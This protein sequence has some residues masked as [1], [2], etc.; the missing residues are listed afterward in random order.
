QQDHRDLFRFLA[1]ELGKVVQ[2]DA[3]AQYDDSANKVNWHLCDSCP[4]FN[5]QPLTDI[6]KEET[7]A[8]WVHQNQKPL[9]IPFVDRETRFGMTM[10]LLK[11]RGLQSVCALPMA[12]A[13]RRLGSLVLASRVEDAYSEEEVRFLSLVANQIALAMD[14]SLNFQESQR[15]QERL[16]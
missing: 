7:V 8:W 14:D 16:Q 2:F 9:V 11:K 6:D 13:H 10:P 5:P 12:T 15:A 1:E 4:D 3:I